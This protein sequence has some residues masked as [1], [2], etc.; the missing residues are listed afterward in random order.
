MWFWFANCS[1]S[2]WVKRGFGMPWLGFVFEHLEQTAPGFDFGCCLVS[3]FLVVSPFFR[4]LFKSGSELTPS[5]ISCHDIPSCFAAPFSGSSSCSCSIYCANPLFL[6]NGLDWQHIN[7]GYSAANFWVAPKWMQDV[8]WSLIS[9]KWS[10]CSLSRRGRCCLIP[11]CS[12]GR[13]TCL[14][15]RSVVGEG[16]VILPN[17]AGCCCLCCCRPT[18]TDLGGAGVKLSAVVSV[19][20]EL[21]PG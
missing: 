9:S 16:R 13:R 11:T 4:Q 1:I 15:S 7:W 8:S 5:V 10:T 3:C 18:G 17:G 20:L 12:K 21:F 14:F 2:S 19:S 6:S